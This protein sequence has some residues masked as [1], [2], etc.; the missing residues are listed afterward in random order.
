MQANSTTLSAHGAKIAPTQPNYNT[1]VAPDN[2][3]FESRETRKQ[4]FHM[5]RDY[6][7]RAEKKRRWSVREDIPVGQVQPRSRPGRRRHRPDVL[8]GRAV[9]ARLP[10]AS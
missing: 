7:D 3:F 5:Y 4:L 8:H 6:F 10:R 2:G 9:P 1:S